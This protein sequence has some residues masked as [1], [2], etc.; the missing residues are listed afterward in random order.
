M[1]A[2]TD[3]RGPYLFVGGRADGYRYSVNASRDEWVVPA[4]IPSPGRGYV[5]YDPGAPLDDEEPHVYDRRTIALGSDLHRVSVDVMIWNR[6]EGRAA[7]V[8]ALE[9]IAAL[10]NGGDRQ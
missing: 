6:M 3:F 9:H 1:G 8:A 2:H 7:Y 4:P 10:V 5:P